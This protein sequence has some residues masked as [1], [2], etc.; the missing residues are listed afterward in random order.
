MSIAIALVIG[1]TKQYLWGY[2]KLHFMAS[3]ISSIAFSPHIHEISYNDG[4]KNYFFK[5]DFKKNPVK[6]HMD[7]YFSGAVSGVSYKLSDSD[8]ERVAPE[9]VKRLEGGGYTVEVVV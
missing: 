9:L 2:N 5:V 1:L 7:R 8:R 6:L 3:Y 4:G